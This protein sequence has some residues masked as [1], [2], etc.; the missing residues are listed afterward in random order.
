MIQRFLFKQ[1]LLNFGLSLLIFSGLFLIFDF[2]ERI[3][4]LISERASILISIEYFLLKIPLIVSYMIPIGI[5]VSTLFTIGLLSKSSEIT[6]MRAS[7]VRIRWIASPAI[8]LG[9]I[10]T[11]VALLLNESIIPFCQRRAREIYNIDIRQKDKRGGYSAS[12]FWWREENYFFSVGS[13]DS[14][15]SELHDINFFKLDKNFRVLERIQAE[16]GNFVDSRFG[17]NLENVSTY[18]F[19]AIGNKDSSLISPHIIS[20]KTFPM[21][22]K[23]TPQDLY[24]VEMDPFAMS[25]SELSSF[26]KESQLAGISS[27][28]YYADL[29]QKLSFP[30]IST[31]L[32]LIIVP[33]SINS[34]RKGSLAPAI[35][36]SNL[37]GF[38]F[39]ALHSF[40]VALG[41]AEIIS[42]LLAAW[43]ANLIF[44]TI[45][46][47]LIATAENPQ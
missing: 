4:N 3:D 37:I 19:D 27:S 44:V 26:I 29:Y 10:A 32:P 16:R 33:L 41:R 34:S 12:N 35:L 30:F 9:L 28:S 1:L 6:A 43:S 46:G 8:F 42:P 23:R 2:F 40:C 17:W 11:C 22:S 39:F 18:L 15:A 45:G 5:L 36:A 14:R 21:V 25:Y 20:F 47:V 24:E 7:G 38:T 31:I 13:F